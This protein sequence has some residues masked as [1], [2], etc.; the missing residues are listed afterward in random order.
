MFPQHAQR[1]LARRH[2]GL[3]RLRQLLLQKEPRHGLVRLVPEAARLDFVISAD[4]G[5]A[6][7]KLDLAR[8]LRDGDADLPEDGR[9]VAVVRHP[10]S[11][12]P[13]TPPRPPPS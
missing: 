7:L 11:T 13:P 10:C 5:H 2:D 4:A 9:S 8:A 12:P 1:R 6:E 3:P